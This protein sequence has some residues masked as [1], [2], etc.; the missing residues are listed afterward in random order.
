MRASRVGLAAAQDAAAREAATAAALQRALAELPLN[1]RGMGALRAGLISLQEL[2]AHQTQRLQEQGHDNGAAR[3]RGRTGT[4]STLAGAAA[5]VSAVPDELLTAHAAGVEG[6]S[7]SDV[8]RALG[9]SRQRSHALMQRAITSLREQLARSAADD[10][11]VAAALQGSGL[12][13]AAYVPARSAPT[14]VRN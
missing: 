12:G 14:R 8:S 13:G 1:E 3:G 10:P 9:V 7:L 6:A 4:A 11:D 5:A 2:E